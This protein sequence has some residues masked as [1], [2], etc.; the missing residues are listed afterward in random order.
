ME[1]EY[2][3]VVVLQSNTLLLVGHESQ[4]CHACRPDRATLGHGFAKFFKGEGQSAAAATTQQPPRLRGLPSAPGHQ[5]AE[6]ES[7]LSGLEHAVR[8]HFDNV[9][10]HLSQDLLLQRALPVHMRDI[11]MLKDEVGKHEGSAGQIGTGSTQC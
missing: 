8:C 10:E 4:C 9:A 11:A 5:L 1:S 3:A 6:F 7:T 2:V